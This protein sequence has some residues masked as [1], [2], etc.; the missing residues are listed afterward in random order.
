M[1]AWTISIASVSFLRRRLR[2]L[3]F[4]RF[5]NHR[6]GD[7]TS[8]SRQGLP[9]A[10]LG[11]SNGKY[12]GSAL[13]RVSTSADLSQSPILDSPKGN[14]ENRAGRF[15]AERQGLRVEWPQKR[16]RLSRNSRDTAAFLADLIGRSTETELVGWRP[17]ANRRLLRFLSLLTGNLTGKSSELGLRR[18]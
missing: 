2:S 18:P 16:L 14:F 17:S 13:P 7:F 10:A 5:G 1:A 9:S 3:A 15:T 4:Q 11:R 8:R 6:R 12:S